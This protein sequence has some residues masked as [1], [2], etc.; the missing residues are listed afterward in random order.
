RQQDFQLASARRLQ[1][2]SQLRAQQSRTVERQ[3]DRTPAER[4]IF[5]L[6][7]RTEVRENLVSTDIKR[8]E[9]H[10]LVACRLDDRAIKTFL[11]LGTRECRGHHE[12]KFGAKQT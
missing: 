4:R 9:S 7:G 12:L 3:A 5:F 1:K 2:R 6:H 10:R 11:L 8:P